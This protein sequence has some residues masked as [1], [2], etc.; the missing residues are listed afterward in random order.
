LSKAKE[1]EMK[2]KN[3]SEWEK[4]SA[5]VMSGM[6]EWVAQ[7]PRATFAEIERETMRRMAQLQARMMEDIV[8]AREAEQVKESVEILRCP[9]CGAEMRPR[10]K[11]KRRIQVQ[12]GQEVTIQRSYWVCPKCGAGIFPPG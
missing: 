10:G 6:R 3:A 7:H 1:D 12:G 2:D 11:R 4:M 5:E 8:R 9:E